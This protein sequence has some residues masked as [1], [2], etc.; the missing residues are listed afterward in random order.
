MYMFYL[1]H[2]FLIPKYIRTSYVTIISFGRGDV[3]RRTHHSTMASYH[4]K[5]LIVQYIFPYTSGSKHI[6]PPQNASKRI[7]RKLST[8]RPKFLLPLYYILVFAIYYSSR[9]CVHSLTS[10]GSLLH[11][12][13][14]AELYSR[15][16]VCQ[17]TFP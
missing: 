16:R 15:E 17:V 8:T 1:A 10:I 14:K 2:T 12:A 5:R 9:R 3:L 7:P 4:K 13:T 11:H 6:K